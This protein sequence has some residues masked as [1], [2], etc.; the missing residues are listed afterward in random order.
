MLF[1]LTIKKHGYILH[2]Y[3]YISF[4]RALQNDNRSMLKIYGQS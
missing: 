3:V 1:I 2:N 4:K